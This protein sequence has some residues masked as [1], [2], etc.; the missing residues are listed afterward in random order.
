MC[1]LRLPG[2]DYIGAGNSTNKKDAQGNAAR[3][4]VNYLVRTGHVNPNDVPKEMGNV[5]ALDAAPVKTEYLSPARS[6][7]QDGMGPNDIGQAYR[8]YNEDGRGNYTYMDRIA[9]QKRVE[10]AED[11]DVNSGIHGN[12]TIENAKSKLHQFMQTNKI[13]ADYKYTPLGPDH[14]RYGIVTM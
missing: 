13:N 7:F 6:V 2:F 9:E 4:Y 3:D 10:D 5:Q 14:T 12:W 11:V 8:A 1:E